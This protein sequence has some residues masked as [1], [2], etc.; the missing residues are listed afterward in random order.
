MTSF[1]R[2]GAV[3]CV[4]A[5]AA[6]TLAVPAFA[7]DIDLP[8]D[9]GDAITGV[10]WNERME[11]A[12]T[13]DEAGRITA[14]DASSS[15]SRPVAF[16]GP[17]QSVQ[18]LSLFDDLL[19]IADVGDAD[20]SR[21]SVTVFRV[22]PAS[23][24]TNFRAWDFSYPGGS[25]DAKA[26]ALSGK[27]RIY[28]VTDGEDPG[29]YMAGLQPSRTGINKL[30][31]AA[32]AP[33]GVTDAVFLDDGITLMLRTAAGV[34][35]LDA[36]SW[37]SRALTTYVDPPQAESI[38]TYGE[39]RMLVGDGK[40][41]RDEPL[42]EGVTT[43]TP[44]PPTKPTSSR[45]PTPGESPTPGPEASESVAPQDIEQEGVS[46]SG[47]VLALLGAGIVAVLAG[48]VVFLVRD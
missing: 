17:T 15:R 14:V 8:S 32:D 39:G 2:R 45:S 31:R 10:A 35:L 4:L 44:G 1:P 24:A 16:T 6:T 12:L 38:T 13:V 22:D 25:Q 36:Y 23:E 46:R 27:G 28:I 34:E 43:V 48:V 5:V 18:A 29:V 19:Y 40:N 20:A 9:V 11:A 42:P 7:D 3:V 21:D 37:E 26:L 41:L 30:V 33:E 47:T